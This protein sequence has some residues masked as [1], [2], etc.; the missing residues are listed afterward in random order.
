[1]KKRFF[2]T[3]SLLGGLG[4]IVAPCVGLSFIDQN[5]ISKMHFTDQLYNK[6][7]NLSVDMPKVFSNDGTV[8]DADHTWVF[9]GGKASGT[10]SDLGT[11]RNYIGHF[12]E[13]IRGIWTNLTVAHT[14]SSYDFYQRYVTDLTRPG[15]TLADINLNWNQIKSSNPESVA[16]LIS[17][18]DFLKENSTSESNLNDFLNQLVVFI[19]SGLSLRNNNGYVFIQKHWATNNIVENSL[20][21]AYN[22]QVDKAIEKIYAVN[23]NYLKKITVINHYVSTDNNLN[24]LEKD[25]NKDNQLNKYGQFEIGEQFAMQTYGNTLVNG[26]LDNINWGALTTTNQ[27]SNLWGGYS[28]KVDLNKDLSNEVYS[29]NANSPTQ[30]FYV[31]EIQTTSPISDYLTNVLP[32]IDSDNDV[33]SPT[34]TVTLPSEVNETNFVYK[35]WLASGYFIEGKVSTYNNSFKILNLQ[36]NKD[37][38][39]KI[40]SI[41][42]KQIPTVYGN[43][44]QS[45]SNSLSLSSQQKLF[46]QK[47]LDNKKLNWVVIGDSITQ[48]IAWTKGWNSATQNFWKSLQQDYGRTNDTLT[49]LSISGNTTIEELNNMKYRVD[50]TKPD[51]VIISLGINDIGVSTANGTDYSQTYLNNISSIINQIKKINP[52]VY[53]LLN[54][55][56]PTIA[57]NIS[58]STINTY[59]SILNQ[60]ATQLSS[61]SNIIIYNGNLNTSFTNIVNN[62]NY[63]YSKDYD[64]FYAQDYLHLGL[65]GSIFMALRW[66]Q[67]LG[68]DV[69]DSR[70]NYM[71]YVL[72]TKKSS[73]SVAPNAIPSASMNNNN[74]TLTVDI[75]NIIS[76]SDVY[77]VYTKVE[78]L[79]TGQIF[80][81]TSSKNQS[82][83]AFDLFDSTNHKLKIT[84]Y[85]YSQTSPNEWVFPSINLNSTANT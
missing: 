65:E 48:G 81:T 34:L 20:I 9:V 40:F 68:F 29:L 55:I 24:F 78:D 3:L 73:T 58:A 80:D 41:D 66:L 25:F 1:M 49:N 37:Y 85:G 75:S 51:I 7:S 38:C 63:Y 71:S 79:D 70:L 19:L 82:S 84:C 53:F 15:T 67:A 83:V 72:L 54:S 27:Y 4:L 30:S 50:Q 62:R 11:A 6:Y 69:N 59:N 31:N 43:T 8:N 61:N 56:I 57:S 26:K 32:T 13:D 28:Y 45:I 10:L 36:P 44:S 76:L 22:N 5:N 21:Q 14:Q 46:Q 42:G 12:Q 52:N 64:F 16:Y 18:E 17:D 47:L 39:L 77:N 60:L 74:S 33:T 23:P 35:L 2:I